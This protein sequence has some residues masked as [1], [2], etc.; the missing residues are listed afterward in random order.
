MTSIISV[1]DEC[2]HIARSATRFASDNPNVANEVGHI[3][4]LPGAAI[5]VR[6]ADEIAKYLPQGSTVLDW[7]CGFGQ[8]AYLLA[9]RGYRVSACDWSLRP[10]IPELMDER[11]GYFSLAHQ[12]RI[13]LADRTFTAVISSGTLEHSHH[14]LD[15]LQEIRRVLKPGGW[16]FVFRF[17]N[18]L[19]ISEYV[20]RRSQRWAHAIRM[21]KRELR[22]LLRMFSFRVAETGYDSFLPIFFGRQLKS[23][24]PLRARFD[25]PITA[26]DRALTTLPITAPFSTSIYCFAQL[27]TEYENVTS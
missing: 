4:N 25:Q 23:L 20:A 10:S 21:S 11:I 7:G 9:N 3:D 2:H 26:L 14:M 6:N 18:E 24:R 27:N 5:Y 17:P 22:F 8:M 16:F 12:S 1:H 19:S 13:D 15:S